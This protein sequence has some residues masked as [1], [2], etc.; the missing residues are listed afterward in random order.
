M[1]L[2]VRLLSLADTP[3]DCGGRAAAASAEARA[4]APYA[5]YSR[6][7]AAT[8]PPGAV[9]RVWSATVAQLLDAAAGGCRPTSCY[10]HLVL[11]AEGQPEQE[12]VVWLAPFAE[13][14]LRDP[15]LQLTV[16]DGGA[17]RK[18]GPPP[19]FT[20]ASEAVAPYAVWELSGGQPPGRFSANALTI[21]PCE[22]RNISWVPQE[23]RARARRPG[24]GP[25]AM[26]RGPRRGAASGRALAEL[27]QH[28]LVASSLWD[29]QAAPATPTAARERLAV[30]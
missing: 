15:R 28:H 6:R 2:L 10:V 19:A 21:H 5:K 12:A 20:V 26:R 11:A 30:V 14:Q 7:V 23:P 4:A 27:L 29:H 13:L 1:T 3:Q 22:P 16:L 8:A 17:P 24:G 25:P 18:H 9:T